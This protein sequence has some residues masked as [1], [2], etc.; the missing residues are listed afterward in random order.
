M[1][2]NLVMTTSAVIVGSGCNHLGR[3]AGERRSVQ[4]PTPPVYSNQP[5]ILRMC[6]NPILDNYNRVVSFPSRRS[7]LGR[8]GCDR[9]GTLGS[10]TTQRSP[11]PNPRMFQ[12]IYCCC[13]RELHDTTACFTQQLNSLLCVAKISADERSQLCARPREV[14]VVGRTDVSI[15]ICR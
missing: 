1:S 12:K 5:R 11:M 3:F 14:Q 10:S 2:S 4:W 15:F 13:S 8:Q 6:T 9:F 7:G